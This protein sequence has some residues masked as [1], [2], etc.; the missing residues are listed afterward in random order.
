L[1]TVLCIVVLRRTRAWFNNR[2]VERLYPLSGKYLSEY[3]DEKDGRAAKVT[4]PVELRQ[5][6]AK[7]RGTTWQGSRAWR[8]DGEI[9]AD[10]YLHGR[11]EPDNK[12]DKGFGFFVLKVDRDCNMDGLWCGRDA[13]LDKFLSGTYSFRRQPNLSIRPITNA[14]VAA[15]MDI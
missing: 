2:R 8:L 9:T 4:A 13:K 3:D 12:R 11:Y 1:L 15:V 14:Q 5:Q 6:G 7:V 10:G